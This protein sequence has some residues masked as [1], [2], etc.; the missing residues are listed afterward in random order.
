VQTPADER[1]V[2]LGD[3]EQEGA[4][5]EAPPA[6]IE[7]RLFLH[8]RPD[9]LG[10]AAREYQ[11][12]QLEGLLHQREQMVVERRNEAIRLLEDFVAHEPEQ[13]VEMPDA[14]LRLAEL[15]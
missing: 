10:A 14:L 12:A 7:E 13:A 9:A 3:D 15:R 1:Q 8:E 2:E 11:D 4:A 5:E 6:D